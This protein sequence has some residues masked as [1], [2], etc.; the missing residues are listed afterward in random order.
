MLS[1]SFVAG[2]ED[3]QPGAFHD[4]GLERQRR[5]LGLG[6]G[7]RVPANRVTLW[8]EPASRQSICLRPKG[9]ISP[10]PGWV[11]IPRGRGYP[12]AGAAIPR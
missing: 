6:D 2:G 11:P 4:R 8:G 12:R 1:R 7:D 9:Q 3:E 5:D 10:R